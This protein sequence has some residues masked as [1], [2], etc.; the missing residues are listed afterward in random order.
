MEQKNYKTFTYNEIKTIS[1]KNYKNGYNRNVN[2]TKFKKSDSFDVYPVL[3]HEHK[4]GI[5]TTPRIRCIC[6][7]QRDKT[8]RP[9]QD[10]TFEQWMSYGI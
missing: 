7:C 8:R 2:P 10:I 5:K 9:I 1:D 4:G 3:I 6:V